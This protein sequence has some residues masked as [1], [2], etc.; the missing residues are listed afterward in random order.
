M[1]W[2]LGTAT[3]GC[4]QH[5]WYGV[6]EVGAEFHSQFPTSTH[7]HRGP[8]LTSFVTNLLFINC[9]LLHKQVTDS[10]CRVL[11]FFPFMVRRPH[12]TNTLWNCRL[13]ECWSPAPH[14]RKMKLIKPTGNF[15][16]NSEVSAFKARS[17]HKCH[18][19]RVCS[20]FKNI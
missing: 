17:C 9:D 14:I 7:R 13:W 3:A 18:T 20:N 12:L 8:N 2:F 10:H 16:S 5:H 1:A 11:H 6:Q 4:R 15:E 19:P